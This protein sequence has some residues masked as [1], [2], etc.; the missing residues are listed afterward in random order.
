MD[1]GGPRYVA[2]GIDRYGGE[3]LTCVFAKEKNNDDKAVPRTYVR[4]G[5]HLD[6]I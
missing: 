3:S 1:H 2:R 4:T 5:S 6:Y